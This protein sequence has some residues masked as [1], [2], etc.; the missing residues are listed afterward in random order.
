MEE[1]TE[2]VFI[3][4]ELRVLPS[5]A[6]SLTLIGDIEALDAALQTEVSAR[7]ASD[8]KDLARKS[9]LQ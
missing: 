5:G 6:Y 8:L 1:E 3:N 9:R 2:E 4:Y 7:I